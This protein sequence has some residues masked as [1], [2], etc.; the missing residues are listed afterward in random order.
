MH[1]VVQRRVHSVRASSTELRAGEDPLDRNSWASLWRLTQHKWTC[2]HE[3][4]VAGLEIRPKLTSCSGSQ[5]CLLTLLLRNICI[6]VLGVIT[7]GGCTTLTG[8]RLKLTHDVAVS[9]GST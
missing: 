1:K 5:V 9:G 8:G 4:R 2:A 7:G 6:T 3:R